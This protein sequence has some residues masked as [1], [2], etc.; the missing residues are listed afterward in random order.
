MYGLVDSNCGKVKGMFSNRWIGGFHSWALI[1]LS[2]HSDIK[3]S[4][5]SYHS[6]IKLSPISDHSDIKL[7]PISDH[8]DIKLSPISDHSDIGL[9][10]SQS[11]YPQYRNN[12]SSN[13][14]YSKKF[15][16]L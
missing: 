7:S 5:I 14:G 3:L 10:G 2:A 13:I 1:L 6:D 16:F 12:I 11:D 15:V 8:S 9:R 4:P